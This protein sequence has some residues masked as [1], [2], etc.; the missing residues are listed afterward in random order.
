LVKNNPVSE[1][2]TTLFKEQTTYKG[3]Q[4]PILSMLRN[5]AVG[6]YR[7]SYQIVGG[8]KRETLLIWGTEDTEISEQMI[9]DIKSF[10]PTLT[11]KPVESVGH[12]IVFQKPDTVNTFI[13]SFL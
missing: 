2:Y 5:N 6:D 7:Q 3:F 4:Q 9:S 1:K 8:Q 11:F 12:G 10:I 13:N